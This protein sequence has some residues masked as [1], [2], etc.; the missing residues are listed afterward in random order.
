MTSTLA[1]AIERRRH[2]RQELV[3]ACKV[4]DIRTLHF[5]PGQTSDLSDSGA[6]IRVD[7]ARPYGPGDELDVALAAS[8]GAVILSERMV[9]A[10][11]RRVLPIDYHN[12]AIAVEFRGG[13]PALA[14]AA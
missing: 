12:Q 6:L 5:T 3:R 13:P 4:R 1:P 7:R 10:V 9:R 11:V 14:L 8:T 2:A